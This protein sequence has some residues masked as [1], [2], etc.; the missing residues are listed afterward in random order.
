MTDFLQFSRHR[1][2]RNIFV[3]AT[4][5][6]VLFVL[7]LGLLDLLTGQTDDWRSIIHTD[8]PINGMT[9]FYLAIAGVFAAQ[10][11]H[12]LY[13]DKNS[14]WK[15]R[16]YLPCV[17]FVFIFGGLDE[18]LE[19]HEW[20]GRHTSMPSALQSHAGTL[21]ITPSFRPSLQG[22]SYFLTLY[23]AGAWV[24]FFLTRSLLRKEPFAWLSF[25]VAMGF[26]T[27]AWAAET[28][29]QQTDSM[30]PPWC[31]IAYVEEVSELFGCLFFALAMIYLSRYLKKSLA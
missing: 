26:H 14:D 3:A 31:Y 28:F 30:P 1:E 8:N 6:S 15:F 17:A 12:A 23:V 27:A 22:L 10:A 7:A 11:A 25:L 16:L 24:F 5:F 21:P 13:R 2:N 4:G 18:L 19:I 9:G 20:A 29:Y